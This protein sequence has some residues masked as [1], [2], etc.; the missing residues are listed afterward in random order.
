MTCVEHI[1]LD[2]LTDFTGS[3]KRAGVFI[4]HINE[5]LHTYSINTTFRIAAFLGQIKQE[6]GSFQ[7]TQEIASG[8]AY[9]G[10]KD[11]GNTEAGDGAKFKGR[12]LLQITGRANYTACSKAL[13]DDYRLLAAPALL[14]TPHL[15]CMSAGW[16][17]QSRGL[18]EL[19]D[20]SDYMNITKKINGGLAAYN[21]RLQFYN[22]ALKLL[23]E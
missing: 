11:L 10:R 5:S 7:F 3:Q 14:A 20:K 12:G 21:L 22:E 4:V 15:A 17:W 8:K 16:F 6:S 23:G 1:T 9:E 13:F 19:A 2:Q 18:N